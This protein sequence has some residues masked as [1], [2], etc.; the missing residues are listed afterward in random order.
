MKSGFIEVNSANLYYEMDGEGTP[1]IL[2][3][4]G[5]ADGRMWNAQFNEFARQYK[6]VRYDRRGFGK[7]KMVAGDYSDHDDLYALMMSLN[8]DRAILVGCSQGAKLSIDFALKY[9]EMTRAL[10]LATPALGGFFYDGPPPAQMDQLEK[11]DKDGDLDLIN[12]LE[13]QIWVDGPHRRPDQVDPKVRELVRDM[14]RIALETPEDLGNEIPLEPPAV[15]RLSEIKGPTL[16]ITGDLDAPPSLARADFLAKNI[17]HAK[18]VTISG[19]AHLP[20][21]E[22]PEEF[23]EHVL[24]FLKSIQMQM[25]RE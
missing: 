17:P 15:N 10:V 8:I 9:P 7:S 13:L 1:L 3:H 16:I 19:T 24:S 2:N 6:T 11:A 18:K 14:N 23:N 20:N 12:E 4:A 22:K 21:M 25:V 5:L